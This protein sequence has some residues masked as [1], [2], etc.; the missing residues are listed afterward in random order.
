MPKKLR[1]IRPVEFKSL[2]DQNG[3]KLEVFTHGGRETPAPRSM[4]SNIVVLGRHF[5][6]R[7]HTRIYFTRRAKDRLN[8][9]VLFDNRTIFIDPDNSIH[10]MRQTLFHEILH[11]YIK[12]A[13][14]EGLSHDQEEK[15]CDMI[16]WE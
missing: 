16:G 11:I 6:V 9:V 3:R 10:A 13:K 12:N 14:I 4:P 5:S 7:Y 1:K 8:G 15:L 2:T